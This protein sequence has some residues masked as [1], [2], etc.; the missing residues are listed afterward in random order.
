MNADQWLVTLNGECF[1][2]QFEREETALPNRIGSYHL[3][4]LRDVRGKGG[5]V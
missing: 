4:R 1:E 5:N 3:F 2:A